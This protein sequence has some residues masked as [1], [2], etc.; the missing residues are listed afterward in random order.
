MKVGLLNISRA[1]CMPVYWTIWYVDFCSL[2]AH[3]WSEFRLGLSC[4]RQTTVASPAI[5][6]NS[7]FIIF[8]SLPRYIIEVFQQLCKTTKKRRYVFQWPWVFITVLTLIIM[9]MVMIVIGPK[10]IRTLSHVYVPQCQYIF[11]SFNGRQVYTWLF[12]SSNVMKRMKCFTA[13]PRGELT[14]DLDLQ[15]RI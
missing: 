6:R 8:T 15:F 2:I 14:Q 4:F 7:L 9:M 1:S 11:V 5:H 10:D 12:L 13:K 3:T